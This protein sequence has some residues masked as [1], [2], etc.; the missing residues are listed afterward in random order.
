MLIRNENKFIIVLSI[1]VSFCNNI[2][3]A[4]DNYITITLQAKGKVEF[5]IKGT[6]EVTIDWGDG[7]IQRSMI[8]ES[9]VSW[10]GLQKF[11][12]EEPY[13][14]Y[15]HRYRS[16]ESQ[17]T[18][19]ITGDDMVFFTCKSNN[20]TS[21]DISNNPKLR[22]LDVS[23]NLLNNLDVS[24][25]VELFYLYCSGN[26]LTGLCLRDNMKISCIDVSFNEF[27]AGAL[28]AMYETFREQPEWGSIWIGSNPGAQFSDLCIAWKK[29]W[30]VCVHPSVRAICLNP[31][32]GEE[33]DEYNAFLKTTNKKL[34]T[35]IIK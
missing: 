28:N 30:I 20:V 14:R 7:N 17:T 32:Q 25:N 6:G 4:T 23:N 26:Q 11:T 24:K 33:I 34:S 29:G 12:N 5:Y 19:T 18:I 1:L 21:L 16:K 10:K 35:S 2:A 3:K 13:E 15:R 22:L 27:S 31:N 8:S 9:S